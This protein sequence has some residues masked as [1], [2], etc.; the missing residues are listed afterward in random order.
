MV[1]IDWP[2]VLGYLFLPFYLNHSFILKGIDDHLKAL[3]VFLTIVVFHSWL[4]LVKKKEKQ[5]TLTRPIEKD[6]CE[7]RIFILKLI[8][9]SKNLEVPFLKLICLKNTFSLLYKQCLHHFSFLFIM[10]PEDHDGRLPE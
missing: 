9:K 3:Q 7:K 6:K 2:I 1:I 4:D 5:S 10:K 8:F